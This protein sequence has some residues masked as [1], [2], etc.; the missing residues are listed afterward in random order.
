MAT[1]EFNYPGIQ[2][3]NSD[4]SDTRTFPHILEYV[5]LKQIIDRSHY[6]STSSKLFNIGELP[7]TPDIMIDLELIHLDVIEDWKK[8]FGD[9][10][11]S[12]IEHISLT[13]Q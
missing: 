5:G 12:R 4:S 9:Y 11:S 7:H 6:H 8:M 3:E 10:G 1:A 13:T 2:R